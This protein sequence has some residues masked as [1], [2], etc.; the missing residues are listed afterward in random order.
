MVSCPYK[1][2]RFCTPV[3][4]L[5][6]LILLTFSYRLE[7]FLL[8]TLISAFLI[9][10]VTS[11]FDKEF[12]LKYCGKIVNIHNTYETDF[13]IVLN[14]TQKEGLNDFKHDKVINDTNENFLTFTLSSKYPVIMIV[15]QFFYSEKY[16]TNLDYETQRE[17]VFSESSNLNFINFIENDGII[18]FE[19][20]FKEIENTY[21]KHHLS[22]NCSEPENGNMFFIYKIQNKCIY[23]V[24][25][26][27][28]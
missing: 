28:S 24:D 16:N 7:K 1:V 4:S 27:N 10:S 21:N 22:V 13:P 20:D 9:C 26:K 2:I 11:V 6:S 23:F 17:I 15:P 3:I 18:R 5:L 12:K 19:N 25:N 14:E 8:I